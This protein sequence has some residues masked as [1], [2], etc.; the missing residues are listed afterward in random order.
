MG[1]TPYHPGAHTLAANPF[2]R[3]RWSLNEIEGKFDASVR[4]LMAIRECT[5]LNVA[6][7]LAAET[8]QIMAR[9]TQ[10]S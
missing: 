3:L 1:K 2:N 9:E 4:A 10:K 5:D 6:R 8:L 7:K